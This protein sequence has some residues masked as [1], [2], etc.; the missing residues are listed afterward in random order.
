MNKA[1]LQL[2]EKVVIVFEELNDEVKKMS[3]KLYGLGWTAKCAYRVY[4]NSDYQNPEKYDAANLAW[5]KA[6][7]HEDLLKWL[8]QLLD[9][10]K[11]FNGY[12]ANYNQFIKELDDGI[13]MALKMKAVEKA[14]I[15]M[16]RRKKLPIPE[17]L[18]T[19]VYRFL[20]ILSTMKTGKDYF[21]E[22]QERFEKYSDEEIL[23]VFNSQV[24]DTGRVYGAATAA[25]SYRAALRHEFIRRGFDY[26][27]IGDSA[28]LSFRDK[29]RLENRTI[30][31][32]KPREV[33][34]PGL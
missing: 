18:E 15:L 17:D 30:L 11:G 24:N 3:S 7:A 13:A 9:T 8:I 29:I 19:N 10:H 21:V 33:N 25:I 23:D 28:S 32:I 27:A 6:S 34:E 12:F 31:K 1:E 22:F 16:F 5:R 2:Q 14:E 4:V 20:P 26:S